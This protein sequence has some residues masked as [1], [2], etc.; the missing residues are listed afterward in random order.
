MKR[1][2]NLDTLDL[3][4]TNNVDQLVILMQPIVKVIAL[5]MI[6]K[7]SVKMD[8]DEL[9]SNG[10]MG[11]I[12][13]IRKFDL[14]KS[15]N[16]KSYAEI[17]IR[18]AILDHLRQ[19]DV[20]PRSAREKINQQLNAKKEIESKKQ[21]KASDIE[22]ANA[23]SFETLEEYY[24][25]T[26]KWSTIQVFSFEDLTGSTLSFDPEDT[27][28]LKP[29]ETLEEEFD[30]SII[31]KKLSLLSLKQKKVVE[32]YYFK[33]MSLKEIGE[34]MSLTESRISQLHISALKILKDS[35][36]E[37]ELALIV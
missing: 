8:F 25:Y 11:L 16:F 6:K 4:K 28:F 21:G 14:N 26:C 32:Y 15:S 2:S 18:G 36:A 1:I 13:A 30:R 20:L 27:H 12:D 5:K 7:Y 31:E 24:Q 9:V 17:R 23:M 34:E 29:D 10:Y 19:E 33:E 22:V 37:E 35:F 3:L